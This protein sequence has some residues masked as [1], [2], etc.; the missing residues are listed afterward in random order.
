MA[1]QA[2]RSLLGCGFALALL[3]PA[4]PGMADDSSPREDPDTHWPTQEWPMTGQDNDQQCNI[5]V[6]FT[7]ARLGNLPSS[8]VAQ[9]QENVSLF[10]AHHGQ[11]VTAAVGGKILTTSKHGIAASCQ[12]ND[13]L[14]LV[15]VATF[16]SGGLVVHHST[17]CG[18][19]VGSPILAP[20]TPPGSVAISAPGLV[21]AF[22]LAEGC[23]R[24]TMTRFVITTTGSKPPFTPYAGE[25]GSEDHGFYELA[26]HFVEG[27]TLANNVI[28]VATNRKNYPLPQGPCYL[29]AIDRNTLA[30]RWKAQLQTGE[31]SQGPVPKGQEPPEPTS[32]FHATTAA[33]VRDDLVVVG[34][35]KYDDSDGSVVGYALIAFNTLD[36]TQRWSFPT[37]AEINPNPVITQDLVIFGTADGRAHALTHDLVIRDRDGKVF[38]ETPWDRRLR[39]QV[40]PFNEPQALADE[41]LYGPALSGDGNFAYFGGSGGRVHRFGIQNGA[42]ASSKTLQYFGEVTY[43]DN[44][45]RLN[46]DSNGALIVRPCRIN[47]PHAVYKSKTLIV[48]C[49]TQ[50]YGTPVNGAY[51]FALKIPDLTFLPDVDAFTMYP[52]SPDFLD[53]DAPAFKFHG[54]PDDFHGFGGVALNFFTYNYIGGLPIFQYDE[55]QRAQ[56]I[57]NTGL[58]YNLSSQYT[59]G[60]TFEDSGGVSI[61]SGYVLA[62]DR[63]GNFLAIPSTKTFNPATGGGTLG[64]FAPPTPGPPDPLGPKPLGPI[65]VFPNPFRPAAATGG[66]AKFRNLPDGTFVELYTLAHERVRLLAPVGNLATWDGRNEA[67]Q[68]VATG[69]YLYRIVLPGDKPPLI[70]RLALIR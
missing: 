33:A 9:P 37:D 23:T 19:T 18:P 17:G 56:Y 68:Q 16:N 55:I 53:I 47:S 66:I 50:N 13:L 69:V 40:R 60:G 63:S 8:G 67:G 27:P 35:R 58:G 2:V 5:T 25:V 22:Y 59:V 45:Y 64:P 24:L 28:Y 48:K 51:M 34:C 29:Y 20:L 49:W 30:D 14:L 3:L 62:T 39:Y 57:F 31:P 46:Y 21:D 44:D 11:A 43:R 1:R 26:T 15:N 32:R 65:E 52:G 38:W 10:Q 41:A 70:G 7:C 6:D 36:G 12:A 4:P 54:A 61:G 42:A